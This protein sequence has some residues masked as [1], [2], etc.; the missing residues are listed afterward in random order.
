MKNQPH[1]LVTALPAVTIIFDLRAKLRKHRKV[2]I[3]DALV[4][5]SAAV[6]FMLLSQALEPSLLAAP[7]KHALVTS[8]N[9][10]YDNSK[11]MKKSATPE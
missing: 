11:L 9:N 8:I 1:V 7:F 10:I 4:T 5:Q 3:R 6:T 2:M